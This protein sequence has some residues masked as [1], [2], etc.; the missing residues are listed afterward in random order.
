MDRAQ[1]IVFYDARWIKALPPSPPTRPGGADPVPPL[2][3][4]VRY[5]LAQA[6]SR[7]ATLGGAY[8]ALSEPLWDTW[9]RD[10]VSALA[11]FARN[12]YRDKFVYLTSRKQARLLQRVR[13]S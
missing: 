4:Y 11:R 10:E 1:V 3:R 2:T 6:R 5:R 7:D 13:A 12:E 9:K 8:W